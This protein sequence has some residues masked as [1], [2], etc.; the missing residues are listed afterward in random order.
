MLAQM[1]MLPVPD[2]TARYTSKQGVQYD[3]DI[4]TF[5]DEKIGNAKGINFFDIYLGQLNLIETLVK[6]A[7][8]LSSINNPLIMA[9]VDFY[10]FP[11]KNTKTTQGLNTNLNTEFVFR[12]AE[13]EFFYRFMGKESF[14]IS[15]W[16][17]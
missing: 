16:A 15:I 7:T 6:N 13:D 5:S 17:S 9:T 3:G 2:K 12:I 11:T 8:K 10:N 1:N 14:K 4:S